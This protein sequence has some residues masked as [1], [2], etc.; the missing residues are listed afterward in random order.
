MSLACRH[1]YS[2]RERSVSI[3][4]TDKPLQ[5][6]AFSVPEGPDPNEPSSD[7]SDSDDDDHTSIEDGLFD[8]LDA[9]PQRDNP[10]P[11]P[12]SPPD[13]E[14]R[15]G[16]MHISEAP[17]PS[18]AVAAAAAP[19]PAPSSSSSSSHRS[20]YLGMFLYGAQDSLAQ[21]M[22]M[23]ERQ[24]PIPG[25]TAW[26]DRCE[27]VS[28]ISHTYFAHLR[29]EVDG[30]SATLASSRNEYYTRMCMQAEQLLR[31]QLS[32]ITPPGAAP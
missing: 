5:P 26:C 11:P 2:P 28:I 17:R 25:V 10:P 4:S 9:P 30:I 12:P 21:N 16:A 3:G 20:T 8:F 29:Q 22:A 13:E 18:G 7:E 27:C 19:H 31:C 14:I 23:I 6:P 32:C 24:R 1:C 15:I